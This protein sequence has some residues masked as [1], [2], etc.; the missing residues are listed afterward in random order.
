LIDA[1]LAFMAA[2]LGARVERHIE[3]A[4]KILAGIPAQAW[5]PSFAGTILGLGVAALAM[6]AR[7]NRFRV[8]L[9]VEPRPAPK[10]RPKLEDG[11]PE[12]RP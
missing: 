2:V 11:R 3:S 8:R 4:G 1:S 7:N 9:E 5:F 10:P 6:W 12:A